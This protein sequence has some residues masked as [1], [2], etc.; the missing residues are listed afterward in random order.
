MNGGRV[1][2]KKGNRFYVSVMAIAISLG[3]APADLKP[4]DDEYR[5]LVALLFSLSR[6][7][8]VG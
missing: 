3:G 2:T 1:S 8:R 5:L 4:I 7:E 6:W